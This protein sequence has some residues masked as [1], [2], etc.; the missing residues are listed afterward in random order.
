MQRKKKYVPTA[1]LDYPNLAELLADAGEPVSLS[2][3]VR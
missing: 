3:G 1:R 2:D